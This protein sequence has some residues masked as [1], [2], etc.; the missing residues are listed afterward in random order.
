MNVANSHP[1]WE[2]H[3]CCCANVTMASLILTLNRPQARNSLSESLLGESAP[4]LRK[5]PPTAASAPSLL[6]GNGPAFCAGHDLKELTARRSD[7]D[8]G[9]R[10]FRQIYDGVQRDDAAD[11]QSAAAGDRR[12]ARRRQRRRMPTGRQLRSRGRIHG[13]QIRHAWRRYRAVL[14]DADGGV[15][16]QCRAQTCDGNAAHR[17]DGIGRG[18]GADWLDQSRRSSRARNAS[19]AFALAK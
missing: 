19:G 9:R 14:L 12:R 18:C 15:V 11:R 10:L 5:L 7:A 1:R 6:A 17:R 8:R 16:A 4:L 2:L 13:R 3:P